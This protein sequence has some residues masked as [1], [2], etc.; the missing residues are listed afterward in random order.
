MSTS[1]CVVSINISSLRSVEHKGKTIQTGIF[2]KPVEGDVFVRALGLDGDQQG[3]KAHHGGVDMA[4][5]A[6]TAD[7]Y[8]YWRTE[9]AQPDLPYGKFGENLT[10]DRLDETDVCIGDRFRI[11]DEVELEV[12]L[13]RAPCSTLAMVMEDKEFAKKFL[14]TLRVGFYLRVIREGRIRAGDQVERTHRDPARLSIAEVTRVMHFD[15]QN[16]AAVTRALSVEALAEK[17]R[18]RFSKAL[19]DA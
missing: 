14:A 17:W 5:Y 1:M 19:A 11:G 15:R 4:V 2:K 18:E 3:D 6:Y 9:L 8:A 16:K 10:I 13:P 7:N 12:S